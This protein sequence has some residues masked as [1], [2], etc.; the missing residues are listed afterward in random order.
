MTEAMLPCIPGL[1]AIEKFMD[2]NKNNAKLRLKKGNSRGLDQKSITSWFKK[3]E[4]AENL[5]LT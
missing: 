2:G 5:L 3:P 4:D 1:Y